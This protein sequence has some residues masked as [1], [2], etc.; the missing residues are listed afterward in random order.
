M[1]CGDV[2]A[3][4]LH[5][6]L[7][8]SHSSCASL[9]VREFARPREVKRVRRE[10]SQTRYVIIGLI[11]GLAVTPRPRAEAKNACSK[12]RDVL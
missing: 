9:G 10:I 2:R 11:S 12:D 1:T 4:E 7:D 3:R 8:A 5:R 6:A